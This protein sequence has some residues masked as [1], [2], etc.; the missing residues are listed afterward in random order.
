MCAH[1]KLTKVGKILWLGT[2]GVMVAGLLAARLEA[3]SYVLSQNG[4]TVGSAELKIAQQ[5]GGFA[6][7]SKANVKMPQLDYSFDQKGT[8]DAAHHLLHVSLDGKVNGTGAKVETDAQGQQFLM[9][10]NAN[11]Q[12]IHTPLAHHAL[13][14]FMPDFDPAGLQM[15]LYLGAAHNNAGLWALIPKQTGSESAMRIMTDAPM[16]GTLDGRQIA[17]NH[18]TVTY[19]ATKAEVFSGPQNELLQ[20]E[21]PNEGF[22]LARKGFVLTPPKRAGAPPPRPAQ[23]QGQQ[24]TQPQ[25]P[26]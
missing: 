18:Y 21:W 24:P 16:Q 7:D 10:I 3:Q 15:M 25:Q 8:L 12:V 13:G 19:D 6:F 1:G 5:G 17:V 14:V 11:G 23:P 22:A 4:T 9:N 26:Q 2:A 20:T